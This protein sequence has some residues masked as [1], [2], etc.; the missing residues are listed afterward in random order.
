MD[1]SEVEITVIKNDEHLLLKDSRTL[2]ADSS[3][4]TTEDGSADITIS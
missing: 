4:S 2:L 3:S 1:G